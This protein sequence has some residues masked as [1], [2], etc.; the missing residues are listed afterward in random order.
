MKVIVYLNDK[1][2]TI[3]K[4]SVHL[5]ELSS[6]EKGN[7]VNIKEFNQQVSSILKNLKINRGIVG[8]DG[9]V[10]LDEMITP[11]NGMFYKEIF[12]ELGFNNV[13][14]CS[15][16]MFLEE[17]N[18]IYLICNKY[19]NFIYLGNNYYELPSLEVFDSLN[20]KN[21]IKIFGNNPRINEVKEILKGK[22]SAKVYMF[23]PPENYI[24]NLIKK[25]M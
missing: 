14:V 17:K 21:P 4:D 5:Y 7:V 8:E 20:C 22:V 13:E 25:I 10:Y 11:I 6:L 24:L 15:I 3:I 19:S 18:T 12:N 9:K 16:K 1:E 2:L 23:Y